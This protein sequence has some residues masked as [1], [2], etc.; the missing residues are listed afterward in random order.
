MVNLMHGEFVD[1]HY[2]VQ[3]Y[4]KQ[5]PEIAVCSQSLFYVVG[6]C[7]GLPAIRLHRVGPRVIIDPASLD[8]RTARSS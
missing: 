1:G 2:V 4:P 8:V 7:E 3:V 6:V 5:M